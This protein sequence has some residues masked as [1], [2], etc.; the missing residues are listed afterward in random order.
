MSEELTCPG[1]GQK[2]D[3]KFGLPGVVLTCKCGKEWILCL[4]K[5]VNRKEFHETADLWHGV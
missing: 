5:L 2:L 1:C 4:G 3:R